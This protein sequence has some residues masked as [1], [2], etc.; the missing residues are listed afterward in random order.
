MTGTSFLQIEN[1]ETYYGVIRALKGISFDVKQGEVVALIGGNGAGK[2][3]TLFTLMGILKP[4]SGKV[5]FDGEEITKKPTEEIVR[6]GLALVP[7]GRQVFGKLSVSENLRMGA[8]TV[9]DNNEYTRRLDEVFT[10]FPRLKERIHQQSGTLSGGEQQMLAMGRAMMQGPR[11]LALDEPSM[12]LAPIVVEEIFRTIRRINEEGVTVLLVEQKAMMALRIANR[13]FVLE[14]G[15]IAL[16]G[17]RDELV[18]NSMIRKTYLGIS[19]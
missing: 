19:D 13:A 1:L 12:G 6:R 4:K 17:T 10:L 8:Y 2:T 7:E 16:G 11:F 9:K 15:S 14:T 18:H 5:I 3:T